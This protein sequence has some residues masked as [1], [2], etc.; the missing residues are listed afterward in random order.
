MNASTYLKNVG[1]SMGYMAVDIYQDINPVTSEFL[2]STKNFGED[3]YSSVSD[4]KGKV[5]EMNQDPDSILGIAKSTA[6]DMASN[7]VSDLKTGKWYNKQRFDELTSESV[8]SDMGFSEDDFNFDFDDED[9]SSSDTDEEDE[10]S[11]DTK[12]QITSSRRNTITNIKSMDRVGQKISGAV[13]TSTFKS[14]QYLGEVNKLGFKEVLRVSN[15]G[16]ASVTNGLAAVNANISSLVQL[17]QP[18]TQH[19][20]NS[21]TFYSKTSEWQEA[22][23]KQLD[24][25]IKL[26]SPAEQKQ[27]EKSFNTIADL[28]GSEGGLNL[29]AMKDNFVNNVKDA[30]SIITSFS[31][32]ISPKTISAAIKGNPLG[33][34]LKSVVEALLPNTFKTAQGK[35]D[36]AF[37]SFSTGL[38][39]K[40]RHSRIASNNSILQTLLDW[41]TPSS[42]YKGSINPGNYVKGKVDWDGK[43]RKALMTVIPHYLAQ[44]T[45][46]LTGNPMQ[47]YDYDSGR[48]VTARDIKRDFE[49]TKRN[50]ANMVGGDYISNMS[51]MA[52]NLASDTTSGMNQEQANQFIGELQN[53][54][55]TAFHS[56]TDEYT[57]I[58]STPKKEED[59]KKRIVLAAKYGLSPES[60]ALIDQYNAV[61]KKNGK[62]GEKLQYMTDIERG[63]TDFGNY[64]KYIE[65]EGGTSTFLFDNSL[66]FNKFKKRDKDTGNTSTVLK[67]KNNVLMSLKDQY[68]NNI[69]FYLQGMYQDLD[70]FAENFDLLIDQGAFTVETGSNGR[71]G[72]VKIRGAKPFSKSAKLTRRKD[73]TIT[74]NENVDQS[75]GDENYNSNNNWEGN[76]SKVGNVNFASVDSAAKE[77]GEFDPYRSMMSAI[78]RNDSR[79]RHTN[80]TEFTPKDY[81]K[82]RQYYQNKYNNKKQQTNEE[83]E[84]IINNYLKQEESYYKLS[85]GVNGKIEDF[86]NKYGLGKFGGKLN[87]ASNKVDSMLDEWMYNNVP[88]ASLLFG[89]GEVGAKSGGLFSGA[90]NAIS[91]TGKKL[92]NKFF[93]GV[94]AGDEED[95]SGSGSGLLGI[96]AGRSRK[97]NEKPIEQVGVDKKGRPVYKTNFGRVV[98][99]VGKTLRKYNGIINEKVT[100]A[101]VNTKK[102]VDEFAQNVKEKATSEETKEKVNDVKSKAKDFANEYKQAVYENILGRYFS[103]DDKKE[104][105][106]VQD[107]TSKAM[108]EAGLAKGSIL[109]G[110]MA[111]AGLS[112][113][114]GAVVNPLVGAAIGASV[115]LISKS[116][117]IQNALFGKEVTVDINGEKVSTGERE[118]GILGKKISNFILKNTN[119]M[120]HG[121]RGAA[122]GG[123]AGSFFG[124]P[125]IGSIVGS[126]IGFI[127][128]SDQAKDKLFGTKLD[129]GSRAD[130]GI[131]KQKFIK[132]IKSRKLGIA[133][134][135]GL[136]TA[137]TLLVGGPFGLVGNILVGSALGFAAENEKFKEDFFGT[138]VGE[139]KNKHREGGLMGMIK[140]RVVDPISEIFRNGSKML[141][142]DIKNGIRELGKTIYEKQLKKAFSKIKKTRAGQALSKVGNAVYSGVKGATKIAIKA[143]TAPGVAIRNGLKKK[144][145]NEGYG[146]IDAT[147]HEL[148]AEEREKARYQLD[149]NGNYKTNEEGN[150]ILNK[151]FSNTR[152]FLDEALSKMNA[153]QL[154]AAK[155]LVYLNK[156]PKKLTENIDTQYRASK[157]NTLNLMQG[158]S[159][160]SDK[161]KNKLLKRI[162]N[163]K[164][165]KDIYNI[166]QSIYRTKELTPEHK[167]S[168]LIALKNQ[169]QALSFKLD[170]DAHNE[171]FNKEYE[172]ATN[173]TK[174]VFE[175]LDISDKGLKQKNDWLKRLSYAKNDN[176]FVKVIDEIR[177]ANIPAEQK[178][179]LLSAIKNQMTIFGTRNEITGSL[180]KANQVLNKK[181]GTDASNIENLDELLNIELKDRGNKNSAKE[182]T[183]NAEA[184]AKKALNIQDITEQVTKIPELLQKISDT[185]NKINSDATGSKPNKAKVNVQN[186]KQEKFNKK[187]EKAKRKYGASPEPVPINKQEDINSEEA[188]VNTGEKTPETNPGTEDT[189]ASGWIK[190]FRK[191]FSAD[192]SGQPKNGDTRTNPSTGASEIYSNGRW[193]EDE[194]STATN[195]AQK[196][197]KE[198]SGFMGTVKGFGTGITSIANNMTSLVK[199]IFGKKEKKKSLLDSLMDGAKNLLFGSGD[200]TN[201]LLGG[202][203][204]FFTGATSGKGIIGTLL[205]K[206]NLGTAIKAG[207]GIG[208]IVAGL[209]GLIS[210]KF[211]DF[212]KKVDNNLGRA[213]DK[214]NVGSKAGYTGVQVTDSNGNKQTVALDKNGKPVVNEETGDYVGTDGKDIK[215]SG[216]KSLDYTGASSTD[217]LSTRVKKS[218]GRGLLTNTKSILDVGVK[219]IGRELG[220]TKVGTKIA[221]FASSSAS[222]AFTKIAEKLGAKAA[223]KGIAQTIANQI[224]KVAGGLEKIPFFKGAAENLDNF[225][226][227]LGKTAQMTAEQKGGEAAAKLGKGILGAAAFAIK[228]LTVAYD[229]EEGWNDATATMKVKNPTTAQKAISGVLRALK[230][231]IPVIGMLIPDATVVDLFIKVVAPALGMDVTEFK[232]QRDEATQE[233]EEYNS[234][235]GT[236]LNWQE[237]SKQVLNRYTWGEKVGNGVKKAGSTIATGAK[238]AVNGVK[239]FFGLNKTATTSA[240]NTSASGSGLYGISAGASNYQS[241]AYSMSSMINETGNSIYNNILASTK[242]TDANINSLTT[243]IDTLD[244]FAK[245]GN[246]NG[247]MNTSLNT[248]SS[249]ND[250]ISPYEKSLYA[251]GKGFMLFK[252]LVYKFGDKALSI[253]E[254]FGINL[255]NK[256]STFIGSAKK[257]SSNIIE[258]L[259]SLISD[260]FKKTKTAE[261]ADTNSIEGGGTGISAGAS[262]ISQLSA[263]NRDKNIGFNNIGEKGCGPA[264]AAMADGDSSMDDAIADAGKYQTAGGTDAAFFSDYFSKK[265]KSTSYMNNTSDIANSVAS[266]KPTVLMGRDSFNTSKANSPFG[267]N[268]HYVVANGIDSDGNVLINDP[269]QSHGNVKYDPSILN[270]VSL[271]I[272][273]GAG[274]GLNRGH[275]FYGMSGAGATDKV[276]ENSTEGMSGTSNSSAKASQSMDRY[277]AIYRYLRGTGLSATAAAAIMGCW[278]NESG[279]KPNRVEGDYLKKF[280][281]A[282]TVLKSPESAQDYTQNILFPAYASSGV[283]VRKNGYKGTDGYLYPGVGLAQWTGPMASKL[284]DYTK[285]KGEDWNTLAGQL[286]YFTNGTG[287][288]S[289]TIKNKLN[290]F[291]DTDS[292]TTYFYNEYE[293]GGSNNHNAAALNPSWVSKRQSSAKTIYNKYNSDNGTIALENLKNIKLTDLNTTGGIA[294]TSENSLGTGTKTNSG[295]NTNGSNSGSSS[296]SG[297]LL[298]TII[299]A[300]T[301]RLGEVAKK[302]TGYDIFGIGDGSDSSNNTENSSTGSESSDA[303]Y[304]NGS[305]LNPKLKSG[306]DPVDYMQSILG[307]ISYSMSGPR[308]PSKGSADCSSTVN[309][310]I[311]KAGGPDTGGYTGAEQTNSN[312]YDVL[313]GKGATLTQADLGGANYSRLK[314]NDMLLFTR[315]YAKGNPKLYPYGVGHVGLY[316]G[317]GKY[318]DHG[319]GMGPKIKDMPGTGLTQVRRLKDITWNSDSSSNNNTSEEAS[320]SGS[321]LNPSARALL[322]YSAGGSGLGLATTSNN[323]SNSYNNSVAAS[324]QQSSNIYT[325]SS[326]IVGNSPMSS[327]NGK[328]ATGKVGTTATKSTPVMDK[329]TALMLKTIITLV[330]QLVD[331][332]SKVDAIYSV[333]AEYVN[334]GGG[335][336]TS[337]QSQAILKAATTYTD[338]TVN[339]QSNIKTSSE[340]ASLRKTVDDIL[341]A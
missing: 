191:R 247:V 170:N 8:L 316:M 204:S 295:S 122:I 240:T 150:R 94:N 273:V 293:M 48:W 27:R 6:T 126:A 306:S 130:N 98:I 25:I 205:G 254:K 142:K 302:V 220:K 99:Q 331:N 271:G 250:I 239:N 325:N 55:S 314:R 62:L 156:N 333:L 16:F 176:D 248:S 102:K 310:A 59:K 288:M 67:D 328:S 304:N 241:T 329:S 63:R 167:N 309:W 163:A 44:I 336:M 158:F 184:E 133:T 236:D 36:K 107:I 101:G 245:K 183:K 202:L 291:K 58:L 208:A 210:G 88:M 280:P 23:S 244:R 189:S 229:F 52:R 95:E 87:N 106:K 83:Y 138:E 190:K 303:K 131:I 312:L 226:V 56:D 89:E 317:N 160:M 192:D 225:G 97:K 20:N 196:D 57:F 230:N 270:N 265:G 17:G 90:A 177:A 147:G 338:S 140:D 119:G 246:I 161:T 206:F 78:S 100:T 214:K 29:G 26:L 284:W 5:Q 79:I 114:T 253:L 179:K 243:S 54:N 339:S 104:A 115:G 311:K 128:N 277:Q 337:E 267:P 235:N 70:F 321:G 28:L 124:S 197:K 330:E 9:F 121:V 13:G 237:Y 65:D 188:E 45:S 103:K 315:D 341:S 40:L 228:V 15:K 203:F 334:N 68:D 238:N 292:A 209:T 182:A 221:N 123:V 46:A 117:T 266:G 252:A 111:G 38:L 154:Q 7:I 269:E 4:F 2:S 14:A 34:V 39:S 201:G 18:I 278:E 233:L 279:N 76:K 53:F 112:I 81:E 96:S 80:N 61:L 37:A 178:E 71:R 216:K 340:L 173:N 49:I 222:K 12:A 289:D 93:N 77:S 297:G 144:A 290:D 105:K 213:N 307:K 127:N 281:G 301:T 108:K 326:S 296:S 51:F 332:T 137:A 21:A 285:G 50:Y 255:G 313:N 42:G 215:G 263:S 113:V 169:K 274:S 259:D 298:S 159:G 153:E 129:D 110:A 258:K 22:T 275:R 109:T 193:V 257:T 66:D 47:V 327:M 19:I 174:N 268:N 286:D 148:T 219:G 181:L 186:K 69:F 195:Q 185:L 207:L 319:S 212:A 261:P 64:M 118:G 157:Q 323:G 234:K 149:E 168:L 1:K 10:I 256:S 11:S 251:I 318:I 145:L 151:G 283:T 187:R 324:M 33:F 223:E 276:N 85:K 41:I 305:G 125:V 120:K 299:G 272:G 139:G 24:Q 260:K 146:W 74:R 194:E 43:S 172:A 141:I 72:K 335:G 73:H 152:S 300:F 287:K 116:N 143:A 162:Q 249:E 82:L 165:E 320:A 171:K 294:T 32:I 217:N 224:M 199:G 92:K 86:Q 91:N 164:S 211:D 232:K 75:I 30:A 282:D 242:S 31:G 231:C 136:G 134:G 3:L 200:G 135:A 132:E 60:L 262:F 84:A 180:K 35:L 198:R 264:A 155:N 322:Y 218:I 227:E 175:N 166:E 308:D